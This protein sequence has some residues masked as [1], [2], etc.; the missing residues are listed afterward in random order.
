MKLQ[1]QVND[2][3]KIGETNSKQATISEHKIGKLQYILTEGLYSDPVTAVIAE[4]TNN[5]IDSVVQA[6]KDPKQ[7]PV[8]VEIGKN[9]QRN[10]FFRVTDKGLGL[11]KNEFENILMNY[12]ESTKE[13]SDETIGCYGLGSKSFL[14]LDRAATFTCRKNGIEYKYLAYQGAQFCEY[15]LL[16]EKETTEE[17]GVIFEIAITGWSERNDF[18]KKAKQKLAYYDTVALTIDDRLIENQITRS[19]D[20]QWSTEN[21]DIYMHVCLKDVYYKLDFSKLGVNSIDVPIG[22]RFGLKDGIV[23]TPSREAIIYTDKVKKIILNK[24]QVVSEWFVDRF[25]KAATGGF[26]SIIT[27]WDSLGNKDKYVDVNSVQFHINPLLD[28]S[29]LIPVDVAVK[30]VI[31]R[32][33]NW[34]KANRSSLLN[35]YKVVSIK[36]INCKIRSDKHAVRNVDEVNE[37]QKGT[38]VLLVNDIPLGYV[39]TYLQHVY[40]KEYCIFVTKFRT[41]KLKEK[42]GL[43]SLYSDLQFR[44]EHKSKW[45]GLIQ[46][47]FRVQ[48]EFTDKMIDVSQIEQTQEFKDWL[49][50][51]KEFIALNGKGRVGNSNYKTLNKQLGDVTI[52]IARTSKVTDDPVFEKKVF[53]ISELYKQD[54]M[55]VI[56]KDKDEANK[57]WRLLKKANIH[58]CFIGNKEITKIPLD[59]IKKF[60]KFEEFMT[61]DCKPFMRIASSILF[62]KVVDEFEEV[63]K[64]RKDIFDKCLSSYV[65]DYNILKGYVHD[66]FED[67]AEENIINAIIAVAEE[68]N[69]YDK[70]Y[71]DVY[72]RLKKAMKSFEFL[73]CLKSPS[74]WQDEEIK[75]YN[76]L[77]NQ[78]LLF[79]KKYYDLEGYELVKKSDPVSKLAVTDEDLELQ[80]EEEEMADLELI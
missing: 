17:N 53:K 9:E 78:M 76:R 23:V 11:D 1:N 48:K 36:N 39:R 62:S 35:E 41:K 31:L 21:Q 2:N 33:A 64:G 47:Y 8:L 10:S 49:I 65:D 40:D 59:C 50:R 75:K 27:A 28:H 25:N 80:L 56:M 30:G 74:Y 29:D 72:T 34:Y 79:Q 20:W 22:L 58:T 60:V 61:R 57:Y 63:M 45:R 3:I 38:K 70:Q 6:G 14:A 71:W 24:I 26:D 68:K 69:L 51:H 54:R 5:G 46:E 73:S 42:F 13:D 55:F 67:G 37:I 19:T 52:S 16:Y 43:A 77:I 12:L 15:D 32:K 66:N 7:F 18:V 44:S 4:I